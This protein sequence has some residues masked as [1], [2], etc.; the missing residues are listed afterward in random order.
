[1]LGRTGRICTLLQF[2]PE[3]GSVMLS[4]VIFHYTEFPFVLS[5]RKVW[6][7]PIIKLLKREMKLVEH[8]LQ[9]P[10]KNEVRINEQLLQQHLNGSG[11]IGQQSQH[12][13]QTSNHSFQRT[14]TSNLS[15]WIF[16]IKIQFWTSGGAGPN[17]SWNFFILHITFC[18][19]SYV[20]REM[21][22]CYR[23]C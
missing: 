20:L 6:I 4:S 21:S 9:N 18:F 19:A 7:T 12:S 10:I 13:R 11:T 16:D 1:M 3:S 5:C 15:C 2:N 23:L 17:K 22:C 14:V 8:A